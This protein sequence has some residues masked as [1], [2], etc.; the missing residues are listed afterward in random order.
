M[1]RRFPG[2]GPARPAD[3]RA[4]DPFRSSAPA[5]SDASVPGPEARH[6]LLIGNGAYREAPLRNPKRDI[7]LVGAALSQLGF[8][9]T[10]IEDGDLATL[11]GAV[12]DFVAR[13]GTSDPGTVALFY[14]A[15]HGVQADGVNYLI[16]ADAAIPEPRWL[17]A[18]ALALDDIVAMLSVSVRKANILVLD[19]CRDG[20]PAWGSTAGGLTGRR[21]F[22]GGLAS[23]TLPPA[24]MLVA[25][26]TAAGMTANDGKGANSPYATALVET[27]P[28]LLEP[29]RRA[30]D[31]F[32]ETAE[33]VREATNGRQ[34][35]ALFLQGGLPALTL[36]PEDAD[37]RAAYDPWGPARARRVALLTG[38]VLFVTLFAVVAGL[39]WA[40]M[41]PIDKRRFLSLA[42]L[43]DPPGSG[44]SCTDPAAMAGP[45]PYGLG[46][47]DWCDLMPADLYRKARASD[48]LDG[49]IAAGAEAGDPRA[50]FLRAMAATERFP[51]LPGSMAESVAFDLDRAARNGLAI[52]AMLWDELA[53]RRILPP[54]L[55]LLES[56]A[57]DGHVPAQAR[58]AV[59]M[60]ERGEV[61]AGVDA[62]N[63]LR[64]RDGTGFA[65]HLLSLVLAGDV[66]PDAVVDLEKSVALTR[67]A[68]RMGYLPAIDRLFELQADGALALGPAETD[69][70]MQRLREVG[71]EEGYWW[72]YDRLLAADTATDDSAAL[73]LLREMMERFP[74]GDAAWQ[75]ADLVTRGIG[76]P[77]PAEELAQAVDQ[78]ISARSPRARTLRGELRMG[79]LQGQDARP[80]LP[81]DPAGALA[82]LQASF[83]LTGEPRALLLLARY[84][85]LGV[86]GRPDPQAAMPY[87]R[88]ALN[89]P[90]GAAAVARHLLAAVDRSAAL[91]ASHLAA[92]IDLGEATA[93]VRVTILLDPGCRDCRGPDGLNALVEWLRATYVRHGFVRLDLRPV[94]P[95]DAPSVA[96]SRLA[97]AG[98]RQ[99][100]A[101]VAHLLS[102]PDAVQPGEGRC[103]EGTETELIVRRNA[104]RLA[105]LRSEVFTRDAAIAPEHLP[106]VAG[107]PAA[108]PP[109]PFLPA[110]LVNGWVL[111]VPDRASLEIT[112]Y[113]LLSPARQIRARDMGARSCQDA[114]MRAVVGS[115]MT[116]PP[117]DNP[118]VQMTELPVVRTPAGGSDAGRGIFCV[119]R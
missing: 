70:L 8:A 67:D 116:A 97:C 73:A 111:S 103:A 101:A 74:Q 102:P 48:H 69:A 85:L 99:D 9:V 92:D 29:G 14:F 15:G 60:V 31:I 28:Q 1:E 62:L 86:G 100:D 114:S 106:D 40:F 47:A 51:A 87:L 43:A 98:G 6:A 88:Q 10:M 34:V 64:G 21:G 65:A 25:Y 113:R 90:D 77:V 117:T 27:L 57:G 84:H 81:I 58:L 105:L 55:D 63:A 16:P 93:P 49:A 33:R 109:R 80:L 108:A 75:F 107:G 68:A 96:V 118:P 45:D 78:A 61:G 23:L 46:A 11:R 66:S 35:P 112:I 110:V 36:A 44:L 83:D 52:A 76:G 53:M 24:G 42:G 38:G 17:S 22:S 39:I 79:L 94:V 41:E 104:E 72:D 56:A 20:E 18:R 12:T 13:L 82:D 91:A 115:L 95:D 32:V 37:R 71:R 89:G 5:N 2:F 50:L 54:R 3:D 26:S 4:E 59:L 19:A 119:G 7:R 30:H